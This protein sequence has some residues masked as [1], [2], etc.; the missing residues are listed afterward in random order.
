M[1]SARQNDFSKLQ[2]LQAMLIEDIFKNKYTKGFLTDIARSGSAPS[3]EVY[4]KFKHDLILIGRCLVSTLPTEFSLSEKK[5]FAA[6]DHF[7]TSAGITQLLNLGII[8]PTDNV[9]RFR[10]LLF[11]TENIEKDFPSGLTS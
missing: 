3:R 9:L 6:S 8:A 10:D 1:D 4:F 5:D 11:A 2:E 7:A